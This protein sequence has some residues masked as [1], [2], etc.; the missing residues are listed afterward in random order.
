MSIE[1]VRQAFGWQP[2]YQGE[3][4]I[5]AQYILKN[6]PNAKSAVIYQNDDYGQDYLD[7]LVKGLGNKAERYRDQQPE[8]EQ[9][10]RRQR[11]SD[12]GDVDRDEA[13]APG[14]AQ[15][16]RDRQ[17]NEQRDGDHKS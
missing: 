11:T 16:Q 3:S 1:K 2:V 8:S 7:G 9:R 12:V 4:L 5:Y 17:G 10:E 13:A 6:T 14:M 15:V